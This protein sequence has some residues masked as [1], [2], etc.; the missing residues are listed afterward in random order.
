MR[1]APDIHMKA[2]LIHASIRDAPQ[3]PKIVASFDLRFHG[4]DT[5]GTMKVPYEG[6]PATLE[7]RV[8]QGRVYVRGYL[9][10]SSGKK[11]PWYLSTPDDLRKRDIP[12]TRGEVTTD[13]ANHAQELSLGADTTVDGKR[14]HSL[15]NSKIKALVLADGPPLLIR[16]TRPSGDDPIYFTYETGAAIK[17]PAHALPAPPSTSETAGALS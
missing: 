13:L 17:A 7:W 6:K 14:C 10:S 11:P 4:D 15:E 5:S 12:T 8:V 9:D 1:Q 3:A 16:E 2:P